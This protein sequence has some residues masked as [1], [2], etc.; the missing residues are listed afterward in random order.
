MKVE[1]RNISKSFGKIE[2][3]KNVDFTLMGGEIHALLG[4]NGAGKSTLMN[5]LG[6]VLPPDEG[7]IYLDGKKV[8]FESPA[9]SLDA[10]IAFIHQELNLINDLTVYE[11]LFIG[12]ELKK[13]NGLLDL[14]RMYLKTKEILERMEIDLDPRTMVRDLDASYKQIVEISRALLM[15]AAVIIMD[16]PTTSLTSS[17]IE[18]VFEMMRVLKK[19]GVGLVFISHKLN[20]V[21]QVCDWYT[22]LRDGEKVADGKVSEVTTE[23]LARMM[24]GHKVR[25]MALQ[26]VRGRGHEVL[27]VEGLTDKHAFREISFSVDAGE[28]LGFTGLLGD[29]RSELFQSIFGAGKDYEGQIYFEGKPI[30]IQ[31]PTQALSLGIGYLPRNRK[32]N[33]ILKDMNILENGT[34]VTWPKNAKFGFIDFDYQT[35]LFDAQVNKLRIKMGERTDPITSLSGGN[36]QKI[37]LAKW[38]IIQPKL[39]ILDN[40]TQGIDVGAKEE[41]YDIIH[42]LADE[43]VAI[44]VLFSEAQEV[45]R[46]CD[47]ALVMYHGELNGELIGENMNEHNVMR[48][49]TGASLNNTIKENNGYD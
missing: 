10:G 22:V 32:E 40:P 3:V 19:Q 13:K 30:E 6:G 9:E 21:I 34:I 35:Q 24:V 18:Q 27:R 48:L 12:R 43:G 7:E 4:E 39:L 14:E 41:I 15:N 11:N 37:V 8:L 1:L 2:A 17:E 23:D 47:R 44:I 20:E 5:I 45:V 28:V 46:V 36:Q 42:D 16:E 38:L 25:T 31:N 29:G 33:G 49:A 26:R